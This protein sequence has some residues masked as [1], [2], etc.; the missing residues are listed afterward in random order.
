M[1]APVLAATDMPLE[2]EADV[3]ASSITVSAPKIAIPASAHHYCFSMDLRS[4]RDLNV[5]FPVNCM[6]RYNV[7][8]VSRMPI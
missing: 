3:Q 4:I 5:G 1:L 6:L 8:N 7:S 2:S